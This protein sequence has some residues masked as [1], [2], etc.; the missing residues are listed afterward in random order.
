MGILPTSSPQLDKEPY[1]QPRTRQVRGRPLL[2]EPSFTNESE[3]KHSNK[4]AEPHKPLHNACCSASNVDASHPELDL[5]RRRSQKSQQLDVICMKTCEW[6]VLFFECSFGRAVVVGMAVGVGGGQGGGLGGTLGC[7]PPSCQPPLSARQT[8]CVGR[9]SSSVADAS[10]HV[11][12]RQW[13]DGE[14]L[15]LI[16]H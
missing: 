5:G 15:V 13:P 16:P 6:A 12:G 9:P 14:P 11:R 7:S 10:P 4:H 2:G 1:R 3:N 8:G